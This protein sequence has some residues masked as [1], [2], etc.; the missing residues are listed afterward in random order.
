MKLYR[1]SD[2]YALSLNKAK[3]PNL[4]FTHY[5]GKAASLWNIVI[6]DTCKL[7]SRTRWNRS[8]E[9]SFVEVLQYLLEISFS[10][11]RYSLK[12]RI[13]KFIHYLTDKNSKL[14]HNFI[15]SYSFCLQALIHY[16]ASTRT[17]L[18]KQITRGENKSQRY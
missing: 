15:K 16:I 17:T 18:I 10:P 9:N 8:Y 11:Y 5:F 1:C 2:H 6:F 3:S 14:I 13:F 4:K 7:V 12:Y